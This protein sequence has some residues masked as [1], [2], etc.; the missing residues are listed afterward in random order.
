MSLSLRLNGRIGNSMTKQ[1]LNYHSSDLD[2][3]GQM[4][5]QQFKDKT[6][7]ELPFSRSTELQFGR[8]DSN[9]NANRT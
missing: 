3:V 8:S 2:K 4:A 6:V 9:S 5:K 7:T 1:S